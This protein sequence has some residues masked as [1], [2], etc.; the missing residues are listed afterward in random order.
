MPG[1]VEGG[2]GGKWKH[3]DVTLSAFLGTFPTSLV[4]TWDGVDEIERSF[5][6]LDKGRV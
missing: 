2:A 3:T 1:S 4:W 6:P 5:L